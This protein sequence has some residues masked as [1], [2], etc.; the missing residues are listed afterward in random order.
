MLEILKCVALSWWESFKAGWITP[1]L[2]PIG[3]IF[4]EMEVEEGTTVEEAY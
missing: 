3:F 4:S 1:N 2:D